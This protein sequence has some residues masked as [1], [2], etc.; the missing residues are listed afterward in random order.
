MNT[1]KSKASGMLILIAGAILCLPQVAGASNAHRGFPDG[2]GRHTAAMATTTGTA[3]TATTETNHRVTATA[4]HVEPPDT[5]APHQATTAVS[6]MLIPP[7]VVFPPAVAARPSPRLR[8]AVV[9]GAD[10]PAAIVPP[11]ADPPVGQLLPSTGSPHVGVIAL[12]GLFLILAGLLIHR[13]AGV[14]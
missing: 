13:S 14:G 11:A 6:V 2:P 7:I 1:P 5:T 10:P 12:G 3:T 8:P 4:A 9:A